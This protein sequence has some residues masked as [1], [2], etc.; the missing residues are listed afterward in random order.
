MSIWECQGNVLHICINFFK[1]I[2]FEFNEKMVIFTKIQWSQSLTIVMFHIW[3]FCLENS[4][5][6]SSTLIILFVS[7]KKLQLLEELCIRIKHET[8]KLNK[9][10]CCLFYMRVNSCI[11][12]FSGFISALRHFPWMNYLK[13]ICLAN[14]QIL[15]WDKRRFVKGFYK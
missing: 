5:M 8:L 9:R 12:A 3:I 7:L 13:G 11:T 6:Y 15:T 10:I 4:Q 14:G 1:K 2:G